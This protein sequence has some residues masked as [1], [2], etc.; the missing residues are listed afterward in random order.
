MEFV[1]VVVGLVAVVWG[2]VLFLRGG[3]IAGCLAVL[4]AGTCFGHAFFHLPTKPI[5]VTIDRLLW[6]LLVAQYILWRGLGKTQSKPLAWSDALLIA[7]LCLLGFSTFTHDWEAGGYQPAARLLFFYLMPFGLYWIARQSGL[8]E[9]G[10]LAMFAAFA[11]FGLYLAATAVAERTGTN[12]L[13]LPGYIASP[14]YPEFLGRARGPLL[15]PIGNGILLGTCLAALMMAWPRAGRLGKLGVL[16]LV[17]M[18][19]AG[20]AATMTRSVWIGAGLG[21]LL[22]VLAALPWNYRAALLVGCVAAGVALTTTRWDS[23]LAFKRDKALSAQETAESVQLRPILA[24]VAWNMFRERPL[25][26]CGYGQYVSASREHLGDRTTDL[27]LE[28]ARPYIQHNTFL[29]LLTETGASGAGLFLAVLALW[30]RDAWRLWRLQNAPLWARQAGLVFLA[31]MANYAVNAM[32]HDVSI[33]PMIHA[34][35][36]F[37]AGTMEAITAHAGR[38]CSGWDSRPAVGLDL[39]V[40][41]ESPR[42]RRFPVPA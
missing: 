13:V 40:S 7:F 3:M 29:S 5:P 19:S 16:L 14:E 21:A 23:L 8:W 24:R 9:R 39:G 32:F 1:M 41:S 10:T 34:L 30:T 22:I 6:L 18:L 28:K 27:P 17:L 33:I 42:E 35:L 11:V 4:L 20:V 38:P 36:F 37:A 15:S 31:L 26:G 25:W 12:A 2:A